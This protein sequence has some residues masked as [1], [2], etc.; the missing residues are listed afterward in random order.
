VV[1]L[2]AYHCLSWSRQNT[3]LLVASYCFYAFWSWKYAFILFGTSL[4]DFFV[5]H[6]IGA[7]TSSRRRHAWLAVAL[8]TNLGVLFTFKYYDFFVGEVADA[9]ALVGIHVRPN[10]LRLGL[11]V[12]IS[13]LTFQEMG[14]TIDVY[15][16][17]MQPTRSLRDYLLFV[18]YFPHL[19]AGPIQ[20]SSHLLRQ[21]EKPRSVRAEQVHTGLIL[22]LSGL[23]RKVVVA[24]GLATYV[25]AVYDNAG[26]ETGKSLVFATYLFAFQIYCD[27]AGYSEMAVG[28][29]RLLGIELIYNFRSP[30]LASSL[31]AFWRSWHIS[32]S[33]WFRDYVFIPLGGSR[34]GQQR[35][36]VNLIT[37]FLVSGLWHGANWTFV[38]WGALHGGMLVVERV[39]LGRRTLGRV[40]RIVGW[41][42]TFNF[43]VLAWVFFRATSMRH[44]WTV[45]RGIAM[46]GPLYWYPPVVS[47]ILGLVLMMTVEVSAG[48]EPVDAWLIRRK[49]GFQFSVGLVLVFALLLLGV[50]SGA[51][52]IYFQF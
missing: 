2:A 19:V 49:P 51:Q 8:A 47:G 28:M 46:P 41:F 14:Y 44:A 23:F 24:D 15:R 48:G 10:L 6:R 38:V 20:R 25:D 16:N 29:S 42:V 17:E 43:V 34:N 27:F 1:V 7:S 52:F 22:L 32:L 37:V 26:H 30:Y 45:L 4:V 40:G 39:L 36:C 18:S 9:L 35:E 3:L 13:F 11:P 50:R 21:L 31:Q 12:G 33:T 5:S